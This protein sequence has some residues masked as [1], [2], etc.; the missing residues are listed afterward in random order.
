MAQRPTFIIPLDMGEYEEIRKREGLPNQRGISTHNLVLKIKRD[1]L[2]RLLLTGYT[3]R[4]CAQHMNHNIETMRRY[5]RNL[6]FQTELRA[7]SETVWKRVDEEIATTKMS[8][9]SRIEDMSDRALSKLNDL[10][11][12]DDERIAQRAVTDVL[13]RNPQTSK[14]H[15]IE[16][17]SRVMVINPAQLALAAKAAVE[18]GIEPPLLT[19]K[20]EQ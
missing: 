16:S 5:A 11:E 3:M 9:A 12:S 7:L 20:D 4:E 10:L 14:H 1:E 2:L 19:G 13:D 8:I 15:K 6:D 18:I 17:E